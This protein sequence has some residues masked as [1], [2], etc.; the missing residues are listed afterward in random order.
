MN[1]A[2]TNATTTG[3]RRGP[4]IVRWTALMLL[5]A[6]LLIPASA[7]AYQQP[8]GFIT[9]GQSESTAAPASNPSPDNEDNMLPIVLSGTAMLIALGSAGFAARTRVRHSPR[10]GA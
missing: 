7:S 5:T 8:G 9:S 6:A 3:S 2:T 4:R 10:L 1:C